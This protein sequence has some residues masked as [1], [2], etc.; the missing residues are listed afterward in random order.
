MIYHGW[1]P[2]KQPHAKNCMCLIC[3]EEREKAQRIEVSIRCDLETM[4]ALENWFYLVGVIHTPILVVLPEHAK[5]G[6]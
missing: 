1:T 5:E 6:A 2:D 4:A 3:D